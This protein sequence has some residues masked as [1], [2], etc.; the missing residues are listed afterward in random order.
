VAV[1]AGAALVRLGAPAVAPLR[2][3][4]TDPAARV[5]AM[6]I[7]GTIGRPAKPALPDMVKALADPDET[8]RSDAAVAIASLGVDAADAVPE[9][10]KLLEGASTPPGTRYSA[11]YALGRIGPAARPALEK[12]RELAA[13]DDELLATVAV[14]AALKIDP[15]DSSLFASAVPRLRKAL[16]SGDEIVRLEAAVALGDIGPDA[17]R[18]LPILELVAEDDPL[19]SVREAAEQ[20]IAKISAANATPARP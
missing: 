16:R 7:L 19:S 14:W 17:K 11:A 9:L 15:A 12:L 3:K 20:A 1:A 4:L 8:Y 18:A 13:T 2:E 10:R 5:A 6:E